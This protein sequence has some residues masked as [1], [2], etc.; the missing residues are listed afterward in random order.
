[1]FTR[2]TAAMPIDQDRM[3]VI[4]KSSV[5]AGRFK[6]YIVG[7]TGWRSYTGSRVA[8]ESA[9]SSWPRGACTDA[10]GFEN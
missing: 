8:V 7:S 6:Q 5:Q 10:Y 9:L 3:Q 2:P 4:F 1:M